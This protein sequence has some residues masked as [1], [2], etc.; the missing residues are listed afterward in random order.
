MNDLDKPA[1]TH[2]EAGGRL[3]MPDATRNV[4]ARRL[5]IAKGHLESILQAVQKEDVYCM[6]VLRQIR[7][8]EGALQKAGQITL[9]SHLRAH[10]ATAAK[11]GDTETIVEEL[12]DAL[13]YR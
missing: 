1:H 10:V 6:D 3:C 13:R 7:A 5:A 8:V 12:M 9:E 4:V 2:Y 11:R